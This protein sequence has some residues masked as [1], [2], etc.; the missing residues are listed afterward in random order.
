M[1]DA[2]TTMMGLA[3]TYPYLALALVLFLAGAGVG[4]KTGKI[5]ALLGAFALL[6]QFDLIATFF[7]LLKSVPDALQELLEVVA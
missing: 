5:L 2:I 1:S 7:S 3:Q 6:Q 4:G